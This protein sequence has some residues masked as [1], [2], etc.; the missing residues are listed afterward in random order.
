VVL[1]GNDE[2]MVDDVKNI[3]AA[4]GVHLNERNM[5]GVLARKGKG[6]KSGDEGAVLEEESVVRV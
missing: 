3:G 2:V 5:F 4:I 1:H 6:K